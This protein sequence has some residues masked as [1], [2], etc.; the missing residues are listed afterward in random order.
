M[1]QQTALS[2]QARIQI[3]K[4]PYEA[5]NAKDWEKVKATITTDFV[6][7]EVALGR[8]TNGIAETLELWKGWAQA[9]PDSVGTFRG[10][11]PSDDGTVTL[12]ITWTGTHRG[13]LQ[14]PAGPIAPTGKRI[15]VFSCAVTEL[16]G[17]KARAQ[18]HYFDMATMLRQIGVL[19]N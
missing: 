6:Y 16:K 19:P 17:D 3:A 9:F 2:P 18:R 5:Y 4:A 8:R 15:E 10:A 7:E 1:A 12:E 14:T 13:P 11:H